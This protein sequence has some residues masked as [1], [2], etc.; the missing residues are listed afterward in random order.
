MPRD[1]RTLDALHVASA[2]ELGDELEAAVAYDRRLLD[3]AAA[4]RLPT[5]S[6]A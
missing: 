4:H 5:A 1:L 2:L 3:A 6:P